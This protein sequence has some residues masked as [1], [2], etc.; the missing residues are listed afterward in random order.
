M[1][2]GGYIIF[3]DANVSSCIGATEAVE[4]IIQRDCMYSEQIWPHYVFRHNLR[5]C[6][7]RA[8]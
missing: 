3:D 5:S 6:Q 7:K 2:Q 8:A 1:V 4:E